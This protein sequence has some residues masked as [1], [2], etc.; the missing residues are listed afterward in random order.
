MPCITRSD[1]GNPGLVDAEKHPLPECGADAYVCIRPLG[2]QDLLQLQKKFGTEA[3]TG[4]L[5]F[6]FDL[7]ARCLVDDNG[8]ILF[9]GADDVRENFN[10]SLKSLKGLVED[11]LLVSG[12][13]T[14]EKN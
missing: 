4:N 12:V 1:L 8:V 11:C 7:L 2:S 9:L 3:E 13:R 6:A 10:L 14:T 5:D